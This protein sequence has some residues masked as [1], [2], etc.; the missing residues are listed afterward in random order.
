[1]LKFGVFFAFKALAGLGNVV[2]V[3]N[4]PRQET[5]SLFEK[6]I[7]RAWEKT[8]IFRI[9]LFDRDIGLS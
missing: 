1:M 2:Y 4:S 5:R 7:D 3:T 6:G 9:E 8:L